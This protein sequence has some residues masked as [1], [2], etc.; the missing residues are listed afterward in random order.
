MLR[1]MGSHA[2][3]NT[4]SV[5]LSYTPLQAPLADLCVT[6]HPPYLVLYDTLG[7]LG[8]E[9]LGGNQDLSAEIKQSHIKDTAASSKHERRYTQTY[10]PPVTPHH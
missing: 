3:L 6:F 4:A 1:L 10:D 7:G 8:T 5:W 9:R 2:Q